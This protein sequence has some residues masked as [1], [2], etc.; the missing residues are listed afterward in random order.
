[1]FASPFADG[2]MSTCHHKVSGGALSG[3]DA[4]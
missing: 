2:S 1:M 3:T 4:L